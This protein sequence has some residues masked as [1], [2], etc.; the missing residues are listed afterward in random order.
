MGISVAYVG[1]PSTGGS[2]GGGGGGGGAT[3]CTR[4]TNAQHVQAGRATQ[5]LIW[6]WAKGSNGYLG[7]NWATT[8]LREGPA[9]TWSLVTAC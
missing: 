2:G 1:E 7:A 3:D 6:A 8:S 9:G 5:W 4:A